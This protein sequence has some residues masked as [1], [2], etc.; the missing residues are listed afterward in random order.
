EMNFISH[1]DSQG[2]PV[3]KGLPTSEGQIAFLASCE[4][5]SLICSSISYAVFCLNKKD[6]EFWNKDFFK[7]WGRNL[8]LIYRSS[9]NFTTKA[10][11]P[12]RWRLDSQIL[13]SKAKRLIPSEDR[14]SFVEFDEVMARC[15]QL[16]KTE[17]DFGLIHADHA[18][19]NFRYE[20]RSRK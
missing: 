10:G 2:V 19:Q 18:P 20:P 16:P 3:A 11:E 5:G 12:T 7:E 8:G 17:N 9:R 4:A 1:L 6:S 15:K 13:I 14:P